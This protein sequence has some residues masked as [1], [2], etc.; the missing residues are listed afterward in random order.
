MDF[1][2][3]TCDNQ[4]PLAVLVR[5]GYASILE[6]IATHS[7]SID[8][9][10]IEDGC[11]IG[12]NRRSLNAL[13]IIACERELPNIAV[14]CKS[15]SLALEIF[16]Q[17]GAAP[18]ASDERGLSCLNK[19]KVNVAVVHQ[20]IKSGAD[21][22]SGKKSFILDAIDNMDLVTVKLLASLGT[23]FNRRLATEEDKNSG[24]DKDEL[25]AMRKA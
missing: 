14:R 23:E 22:S 16:L 25:K 10:W 1:L 12:Q 21:A 7:S 15:W 24:H 5:W 19:A 9:S 17:H 8:K 20:P 4:S 6:K 2:K 13:L 18:N 11:L 3:P